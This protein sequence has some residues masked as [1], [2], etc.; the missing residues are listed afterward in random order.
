MTSFFFFS[1]V[2][3]VILIVYIIKVAKAS[4]EKALAENGEID[5]IDLNSP[6]LPIRADSTQLSLH[7]P[8]ITRVDTNTTTDDLV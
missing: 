8:L 7:R 3:T 2:L 1:H 5:V 6:G 4:L